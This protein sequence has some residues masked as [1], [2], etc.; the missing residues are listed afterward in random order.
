M[1]TYQAWRDGQRWARIGI[2]LA[3]TGM[4]AA[5]AVAFSI[6]RTL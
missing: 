5:A 2:A 3:G 1:S 4:I 6:W